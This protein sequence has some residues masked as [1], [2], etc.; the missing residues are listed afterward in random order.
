MKGVLLHYSLPCSREAESLTTLA[1]CLSARLASQQVTAVFHIHPSSHI[2]GAYY[3]YMWLGGVLRFL[4][5]FE[6]W[7][8]CLA[9]SH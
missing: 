9:S 1:G 4:P 3:R 8:S 5:G 7:S 6:S 2:A